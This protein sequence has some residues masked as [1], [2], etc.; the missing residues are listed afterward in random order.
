[1]IVDGPVRQLDMNRQVLIKPAG[2]GKPV[3]VWASV[4]R[5]P[6]GYTDHS[7]VL[8]VAR[9]LNFWLDQ[10]RLTSDSENRP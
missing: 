10:V 5:L 1:M 3:L 6:Q 9:I 2:L 8:P 4:W 7:G